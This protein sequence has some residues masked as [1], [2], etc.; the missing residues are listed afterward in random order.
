MLWINMYVRLVV[1]FMILSR[2]IPIQALPLAHPLKISLRIGFAPFAELVRI[3]SKRKNRFKQ[4]TGS[5]AVITQADSFF[6]RMA[7]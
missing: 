4:K 2:E 5:A 7:N 6:E 1:T 3:C